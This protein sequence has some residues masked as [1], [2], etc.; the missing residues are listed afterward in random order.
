MY[1]LLGMRLA[2]NIVPQLLLSAPSFAVLSYFASAYVVM[3]PQLRFEGFTSGQ[4]NLRG[5]VLSLMIMVLIFLLLV[6]MYSL[7]FSLYA[8]AAS[9]IATVPL[10][11]FSGPWGSA[12]RRLVEKGY[13]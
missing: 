7:A 2:L 13:V 11:S 10:I 9:L 1:L 8:A 5:L 12:S 4:A 3:A 6:S